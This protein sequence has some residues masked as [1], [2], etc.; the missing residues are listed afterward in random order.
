MKLA[1]SRMSTFAVSARA[2]DLAFLRGVLE[3]SE[4]LGVITGSRGG[5]VYVLTPTS[6]EAELAELL[7]ELGSEL[8]FVA[9]KRDASSSELLDLGAK[10]GIS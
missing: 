6:R 1:L 2:H 8:G 9:T 3:A 7:A 5:E 10:H 4:G